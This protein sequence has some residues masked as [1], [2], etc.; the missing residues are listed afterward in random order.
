MPGQSLRFVR[1]SEVFDRECTQATLEHTRKPRIVQVL[2]A[3][4][5]RV[6][7]SIADLPVHFMV[8]AGLQPAPGADC[9]APSDVTLTEWWPGQIS[10]HL[11]EGNLLA[12]R[13]ADL[14]PALCHITRITIKPIEKE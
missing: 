14:E 10:D 11:C 2:A 12:V 3:V 6:V 4:S 1:Q 8:D 7:E 5:F 9:A 13:C